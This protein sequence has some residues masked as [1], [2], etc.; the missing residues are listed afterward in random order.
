MKL[1]KTKREIFPDPM[2]AEEDGV[3]CYGGEASPDFLFEAYSIG[4]FPWPQAEGPLLWFSPARRGILEFQNLHWS[5]SFLKDLKKLKWQITQNK[6]FREVILSCR[7]SV[8]PG[9]TG[10]WIREDMI[11]GYCDFHHEGYAHSVEC[12]DGD[13]LVGG[14][15]GV[16]IG[17]VFAGESMFFKE[18]GSS[19]I[20]LW[21]LTEQLKTEGRTWM[22]IQMVTPFMSQLGGEY[23]NRKDFL[24]KLKATH[25]LARNM[26]S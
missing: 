4:V 26:Q 8:R 21:W 9:Q 19:K 10:T 7:E 2:N 13:R 25:R 5:K 12:W 14:L 18:S 23:I 3:L 15:Y 11:E 22:D 20:C 17:G 6:A 24:K 1:A 16:D